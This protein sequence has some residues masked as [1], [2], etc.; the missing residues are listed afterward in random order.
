MAGIEKI[1]K[2]AAGE[3]SKAAAWKK[4]NTEIVDH[5]EDTHWFYP[6]GGS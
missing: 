1:G 6:Q 2:M 5:Y 4:E 3:P